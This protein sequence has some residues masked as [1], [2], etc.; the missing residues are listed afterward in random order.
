MMAWD[1]LECFPDEEIEL[2]QSE[3]ERDIECI[4]FD[5]ENREVTCTRDPINRLLK[6]ILTFAHLSLNSNICPAAKFV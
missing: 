6:I 2:S 5:L 3:L 1:A 4:R